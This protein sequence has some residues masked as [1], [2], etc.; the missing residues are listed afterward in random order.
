[1][2]QPQRLLVK[3]RSQ[4]SLGAADPKVNL[5]PLFEKSAASSGFGL[6]GAAPAWFIADVPEA[7]PTPWDAA[8]NQAASAMGL[9][10][11]A[12]LFAEPDLPQSYPDD[13]EGNAGGSPFAISQPTCTFQDQNDDQRP[14]GPGFAWHLRDEFSQLG[15]AHG[16]VAFSD[17]N[18]TRIAHIDTGY[19]PSHVA[20]P[21]RILKTLERNF[22][23]ADG[24]PN[25]AADPNR[26]FLFDQSGHGTGTIGILAGPTVPQNGN[27]PYGGAPD[28][29]ILP[30]RMREL[31]WSSS[32]RA[33]SPKR[34]NMRFNHLLT[35]WLPSAWEACLPLHGTM[36]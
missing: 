18:R 25:S 22:V 10:S 23:N 14:P 31:L 13:N 32:L 36:R 28:A 5:S 1:M 24:T 26:G 35:V 21:A 34:F 19:D 9:D 29:D 6:T 4:T 15:A 16:A 12:V 2:P 7:G 20:R 8:H 33:R 3:L 30:L 17:P 27:Q 11:V